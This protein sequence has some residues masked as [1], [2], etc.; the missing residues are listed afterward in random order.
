MTRIA[1]A[2]LLWTTARA[3]EP[4]ADELLANYDAASGHSFDAQM[5]M[6]AHRQDG[7]TRV[8][9]FRIAKTPDD[10]VRAW[11]SEP[12]SAKG[13]EMLRVGDNMWVYMPSLK[14]ALRIESRESFQGGDFRN[15]EI[16]RPTLRADY[17]AKLLPSENPALHALELTAKSREAP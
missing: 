14:R 11:F 15:G 2:L 4:T 12:A 7:T 9:K 10:K 3:A 13:Q 5:T 6:T 16:L 1:I 8:Y 17:S